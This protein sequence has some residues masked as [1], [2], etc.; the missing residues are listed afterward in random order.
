MAVREEPEERTSSLMAAPPEPR[1]RMQVVPP[2]GATH[3]S[4]YRVETT[5]NGHGRRMKMTGP[6]EDNGQVPDAWPV[7][8]FSTGQVLKMWGDGKY[9]VEWYGG[10]GER[11]ASAGQLFEVATPSP[12]TAKQRK[13][14]PPRRSARV[15]AAPEDEVIERAAQG[16]VG[17]IGILEILTLLRS[18]REE[19][20]ELAAAQAERDRQFW[21]QM[22]AQQTQLLT[23]ILGRG[24]GQVDGEILRREMAVTVREGMA[25]L[26]RDLDSQREEDDGD[27]PEPGLDPPRDMSEA[28]ER[29]GLSFLSELEGAAPA[30][31]QKMVPA[32]VE[33]MQSKGLVPSPE[34]QARIEAA[35]HANGV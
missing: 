31:V 22:Q 28:A 18:E 1:K 29:I 32:F 13:L 5:A 15:E 33:F 7:D 20:R 19:A 9:K 27:D 16:G 30:I 24:G 21:A 11:I 35:R 23:T 14:Q 34:L 4:I 10:D 26:R 17:G 25:Q 8:Q 12:A 3:W 2:P 6:P